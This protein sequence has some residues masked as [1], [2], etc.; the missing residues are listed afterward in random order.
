[1]LTSKAGVLKDQDSYRLINMNPFSVNSPQQSLFTKVE[2]VRRHHSKVKDSHITL[3]HGGGGKAMR[4]LI[5]DIF[6]G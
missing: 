2:Q 5:D 4:D 6:V 3:A 1:M